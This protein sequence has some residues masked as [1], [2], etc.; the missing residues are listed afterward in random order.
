M[1]DLKRRMYEDRA[2]RDAAKALV[3]ADVAHLRNGLQSKSIGERV[4]G[5][6]GEGA[7]DVFESAADVADNHKGALA[8]LIGAIMLWF[9]RN[10]IL[11][12]FLDDE[13]GSETPKQ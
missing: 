4:L 3:E 7:K 12:L 2:L 1:A 11:S 10:P 13:E 8:A 9:A 6:I 5:N